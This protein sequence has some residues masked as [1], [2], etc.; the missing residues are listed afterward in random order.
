LHDRLTA[1]GY[2]VTVAHAQQVKLICAIARLDRGGEVSMSHVTII[3]HVAPEGPGLIRDALLTCG[4]ALRL[5]RVYAGELIPSSLDTTA[6]LVVMGGPMGVRDWDRHPH[7]REVYRLIE[8]ALEARV[9]MLGVCLGSQLLAAALGAEVCPGRRKEIGW[10]PVTL[11]DVAARDRLLAGIRSPFTA[12]HWHGD[13]FDL[14]ARAVPL[15]SSACTPCEAFR[16]GETA[17]GLLFH[18]E[19]DAAIVAAMVETFGDELAA[20]GGDRRRVIADAERHLPALDR[21]GGTVFG[22]WA[23]LVQEAEAVRRPSDRPG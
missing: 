13:V 3:Q 11:T 9:P 12:F 1:A 4:I 22:R 10:H 18:L 7:L 6:G 23:A 14:P 2:Q 19:V 15:A 21:V 16:W 5:V 20:A 17:Y 8:T